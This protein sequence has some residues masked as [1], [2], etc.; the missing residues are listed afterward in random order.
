MLHLIRRLGR[1]TEN[2]GENQLERAERTSTEPLRTAAGANSESR[3][4]PRLPE[5]FAHQRP[6]AGLA[7]PGHVFGLA[8]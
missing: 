8:H 7:F 6:F 4:Y 1:S 5:N 3:R 2:T